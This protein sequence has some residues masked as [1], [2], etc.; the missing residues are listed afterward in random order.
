MKCEP[1]TIKAL[2]EIT[3]TLIRQGKGNLPILIGSACTKEN[4]LQIGKFI[5][6]AVAELSFS[7]DFEDGEDEGGEL[8]VLS[9][10]P[11][12]FNVL[13]DENHTLKF[14]MDPSDDEYLQY[15]SEL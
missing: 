1:F 2:H 7:K 5:S 10:H 11:F 6:Y 14:L 4:E 12:L 13:T 8:M 9:D 15:R 3:G